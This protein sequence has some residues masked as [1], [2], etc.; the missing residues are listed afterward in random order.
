CLKYEKH[1]SMLAPMPLALDLDIVNI[2]AQGVWT[3]NYHNY[4]LSEFL[5]T[6]L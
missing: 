2:N 6:Q 1:K 4:Y 5:T 3:N